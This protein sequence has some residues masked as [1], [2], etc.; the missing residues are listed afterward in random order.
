MGLADEP[1]DAGLQWVD[2]IDL[3]HP[4]S[5]APHPA[6]PIPPSLLPSSGT[7]DHPP[8][9]SMLVMGRSSCLC[10]GEAP[11]A[12]TKSMATQARWSFFASLMKTLDDEEEDDVLGMLFANNSDDDFVSPPSGLGNGFGGRGDAKHFRTKLRPR[13]VSSMTTTAATAIKKATRVLHA[14]TRY[15]FLCLFS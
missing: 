6:S 9:A 11:I 2:D 10:L 5:P 4:P 14:G 13:I 3:A 7:H 12:L 15:P 1:A 8:S